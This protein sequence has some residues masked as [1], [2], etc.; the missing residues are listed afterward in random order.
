LVADIQSEDETCFL[1]K[2]F[3]KKKKKGLKSTESAAATGTTATEGTAVGRKG[4]KKGRRTAKKSRMTLAER[5]EPQLS[6]AI[7]KL[8][9]AG[10]VTIA[11]DGLILVKKRWFIP[12][13]LRKRVLL[14]HHS[15]IHKIHAGGPAM[16]ADMCRYVYWPRMNEDVRVFVR[17]CPACQ[18][19]KGRLRK[20]WMPGRVTIPSRRFEVVAVDLVGPMP[21]DRLGNRYILTIQCQFSRFIKAAA[22]KSGGALEIAHSLLNVWILEFGVPRC[23]LSDNGSQFTGKLWSR[24]SRVLGMAHRLISV[25]HPQANGRLERWHEFLK[26]RLRV[27]AVANAARWSDGDEWSLLLPSICAAYNGA[28][29]TVTG[30]APFE[31]IYGEPPAMPWRKLTTELARAEGRSRVKGD[32]ALV[33]TL[34]SSLRTLWDS[35]RENEKRWRLANADKLG[36]RRR[37]PGVTLRVGDKVIMFTADQRRW[38]AKKLSPYFIGPFL[39]EKVNATRIL[40]REPKALTNKWVQRSRLKLFVEPLSQVRL[41]TSLEGA[42][43][44]KKV[45]RLQSEVA[46]LRSGALRVYR[47]GDHGLTVETPATLARALAQCAL[48][49]ADD[50][51]VVELMAG[52]GAITEG[53]PPGT[54]A[55]EWDSARGELGRSRAPHATWLSEDCFSEAVLTRALTEHASV[56]VA[57]PEF[58]DTLAVL[59]VCQEWVLPKGEGQKPGQIVLLLPSNIFDNS[60][61]W[62]DFAVLQLRVVEEL[63]VGR[64]AYYPEYGARKRAADSIFIF[65]LG[66][67][68]TPMAAWPVR[69]L[70]RDKRRGLQ[71]QEGVAEVA[72]HTA[73]ADANPRSDLSDVEDS[74]SEDQGGSDGTGT[75]ARDDGRT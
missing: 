44:S 15:S 46:T 19:S 52:S 49:L 50:N 8:V 33:R 31:L 55:I 2:I 75:H 48:D 25:Y 72:T 43:L 27:M 9:N 74:K 11:S 24:L 20:E 66:M 41:K 18:Q 3:L 67:D 4:R 37:R 56:C 60:A 64:W 59:R 71:V 21:K 7:R 12:T 5:A 69:G 1:I 53:L 32:R 47:T 30:V 6:M 40:I 73:R 10:D 28:V 14:F 62:Q 45:E 26:S 17:C 34:R 36:R 42:P 38:N 57:N 54:L 68:K 13:L 35:A 58:A 29:H 22:L 16:I 61:V 51:Q 70:R 63:R 39:V 65:E 23:L